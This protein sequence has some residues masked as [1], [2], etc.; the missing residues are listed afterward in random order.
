MFIPDQAETTGTGTDRN[1]AVLDNGTAKCWG[2]NYYGSLGQG[3]LDDR[4]DQPGELASMPPIAMGTGRTINA[5]AATEGYY[6]CAKLDNSQLK[7]WGAGEVGNLGYEDTLDRGDQPGEMGDALPTVNLGGTVAFVPAP[8]GDS[9]ETVETIEDVAS[10][11]DDDDGGGL[12]DFDDEDLVD[13][14]DEGVDPELDEPDAGG[15]S[16]SRGGGSLVTATLLALALATRR[17]RRRMR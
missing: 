17:R 9:V 8:L 7:C 12:G 10:P 16:T 6:G 2:W 13:R 14:S 11:A 4:G 3:D 5:L 15:C 1:C